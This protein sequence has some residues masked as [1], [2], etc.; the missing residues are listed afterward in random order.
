MEGLC[1]ARKGFAQATSKWRTQKCSIFEKSI[2]LG[3]IFGGLGQLRTASGKLYAVQTDGLIVI[4]GNKETM[5]TQLLSTLIKV[6]TPLAGIILVLVIAK[7]RNISWE[8]ELGIQRPEM[9]ALFLW[10]GIW[11]VWLVIAEWLIH[12]LNLEQAT[13]WPHYPTLILILRIIA[14]GILGPFAEEIVMRGII[15]SRLRRTRLQPVGAIIVI[16]CGWAALH[17]RYEFST[18]GLIAIDG[19]FLGFA[20]HKSDSI[21]VP[22]A[23]HAIGNLISISQSIWGFGI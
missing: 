8:T 21:W 16:A 22:F 18:L 7:L 17:A 10:I 14:I 6:G 12:L 1:F 2:R 20:R 4:K 5:Q 19:L 9:K 11:L 3:V 13:P 23:M 15:F